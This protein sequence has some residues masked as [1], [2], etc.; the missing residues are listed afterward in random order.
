[1]ECLPQTR[2]YAMPCHCHTSQPTQVL[3]FPLTD[4][5]TSS[6]TKGGRRW[7]QSLA[8]FIAHK[9]Q[10]IYSLEIFVLK[11]LPKRSIVSYLGK[12]E[13]QTSQKKN[14][15]AY[16]QILFPLNNTMSS[17]S[18]NVAIHENT[19]RP[20]SIIACST[21]TLTIFIYEKLSIRNGFHF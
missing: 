16:S 12:I 1:M 11:S 5:G 18:N 2:H 21:F 4:T 17:S 13:R 20:G 6:Y 10:V 3:S 9:L 7:A 8:D 19:G 14:C 15:R